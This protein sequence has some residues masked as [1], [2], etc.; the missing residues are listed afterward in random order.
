[1]TLFIAGA[2]RRKKW[3]KI[4]GVTASMDLSRNKVTLTRTIVGLI[5]L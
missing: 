2:R 4:P 3:A 5:L 1:M